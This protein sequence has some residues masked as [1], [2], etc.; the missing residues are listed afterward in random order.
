MKAISSFVLAAT[1]AAGALPAAAQFAKPEDAVRY[2]QANMTMLGYH[3]GRLGA[4]A[5]GKIPFDAKAAADHAAAAEALSKMPW[6][7]FVPGSDMDGN[8]KALP[9]I[10]KEPAKFKDMANK[11]MAEVTKLNAAAKVGTLDALKGQFGTT[12]GTCKG[13][14]DKFQA[15]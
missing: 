3:I 7:A 6:F 5:N 2:R 14:H 12:G 15:N 13:C 8:T 1:L 4:M 9:A 11:M 10:W